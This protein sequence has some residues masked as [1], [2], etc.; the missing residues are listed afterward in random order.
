MLGSFDKPTQHNLEALLNGTSSAL[1][2]RGQNLNDALGNL[3]PAV[4]EL[5]AMVGVLNQQQGNVRQVISSG[6]TVLT[7]WAGAA[8][9]CRP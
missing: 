5:T 8:P 7:R 6:A 3:D 4:T 9:S 1:A 2:G